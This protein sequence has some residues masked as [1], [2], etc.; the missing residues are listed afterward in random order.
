MRAW[1]NRGHPS[2]TCAG[3]NNTTAGHVVRRAAP[4]EALVTVHV[5]AGLSNAAFLTDLAMKQSDHRD[6]AAQAAAEVESL[7][8]QIRRFEDAAISGGAA[9]D[10]F[11]RVIEGL[12]AR[13][14]EAQAR[15]GQVSGVPASVLAMAGER[16]AGEWDAAGLELQRLAIRTLLW[17]VVHKSSTRVGFDASTVEITTRYGVQQSR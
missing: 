11:G 17:V 1:R 4:L 7:R 5:I 2:Y 16:A 12:H 10:S 6:K 13:L 3:V 14:V 9:A 15:V 8:E